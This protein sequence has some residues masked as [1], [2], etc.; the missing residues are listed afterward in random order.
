MTPN[1][2]A[3]APRH[4]TDLAPPPLATRPIVEVKSVS[5]TYPGGIEAL[6]GISLDFP[7][8][9]L[10]TLLGPSGCGKTT[11]LKIIA[12]LIPASGGQVFVDGTRGEG[13]LVPN[14]PSS[15]RISR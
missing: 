12:G 15:S 5:K 14:A 4:I 8:G 10:T 3:A 13:S 11:L 6:S 7:E 9:R 1:V 2:A